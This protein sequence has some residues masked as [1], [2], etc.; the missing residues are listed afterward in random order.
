MSFIVLGHKIIFLFLSLTSI[1]IFV[2]WE[3]E[4]GFNLHGLSSPLL[5][6]NEEMNVDHID[7]CHSALTVCIYDSICDKSLSV[8]RV[9]SLTRCTEQFIS[10][11]LSRNKY[12]NFFYEDIRL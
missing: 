2:T 6:Y 12:F 7:L 1:C 9:H 5:A 11:I 3:F 4:K 10:L 8:L